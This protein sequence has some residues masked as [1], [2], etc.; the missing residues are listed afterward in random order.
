MPRTVKKTTVT[1]KKPS[2]HRKKHSMTKKGVTKLVKQVIARRVE[3]KEYVASFNKNPLCLQATTAT[4]INNYIVLN[5]SASAS[6]YSIARGTGSGQ[7]V[8]NKIR[9]KR[10]ILNLVISPNPYNV[11]TNPFPSPVMIR[12]YLYKWKRQPQNEPQL[13]NMVGAAGDFFEYGNTD[14][15]FIG[16]LSDLN[17]RINNDAYTYLWH[18]TYKVGPAIEYNGAATATPLYSLSSNDYKLDVVKRIDLTRFIQKRLVQEDT[19]NIFQNPYHVLLMQ[20]I[21][22]TGAAFAST[23]QAVNVAADIHF[24][25]TDM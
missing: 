20:V 17:Q 6:G 13:L 7:M 12:F 3:I 16:G 14:T 10:L 8:G 19:S 2:T 23:V 4:M 21:A 24:Q 18:R 9:T 11:T 5:P 1:I 22:P 15:A 25:Y